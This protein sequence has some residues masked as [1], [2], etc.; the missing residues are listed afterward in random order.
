VNFFHR[1][2]ENYNNFLLSWV[3][4]YNE[5]VISTTTTAFAFIYNFITKKCVAYSQ[6]N[7]LWTWM[8][9]NS[10]LILVV[11]N[12]ALQSRSFSD[13]RL[14]A[15]NTIIR[16][17]LHLSYPIEYCNNNITQFYPNTV[18]KLFHYFFSILSLS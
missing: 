17:F 8:N 7:F 12:T 16:H 18:Q 4:F 2:I 15:Y 5:N 10:A 13:N 9:E 3:N 11:F 14:F 1:T 6:V